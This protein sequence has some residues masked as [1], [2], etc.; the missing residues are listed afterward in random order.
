[1]RSS[2]Q[3]WLCGTSV[4]IR[5]KISGV[6][7]MPM[8]HSSSEQPLIAD[9]HKEPYEKPAF[10]HEQVFVTTALSCGKIDPTQATCHMN[11]KAS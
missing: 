8:D 9:N 5:A 1:M 7:L 6:S 2:D 10:R 3:R 11:P 4:A